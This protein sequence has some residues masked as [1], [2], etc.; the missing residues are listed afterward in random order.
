M[1]FQSITAS[2]Q[3]GQEAGAGKGQGRDEEWNPEVRLSESSSDEAGSVVMGA[4]G[5]ESGFVSAHCKAGGWG[6]GSLT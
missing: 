6:F 3:G 2:P 5:W 1:P 4:R